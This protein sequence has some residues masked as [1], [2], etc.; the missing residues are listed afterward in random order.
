MFV[1]YNLSVHNRSLFV[2]LFS[3]AGGLDLGLEQA[4]WECVYASDLD[5]EAVASLRANQGRSVAEGV[6]FLGSAWVEQRDVCDLKAET[7][8]QLTGGRSTRIELLAGGPP[9]QAWSSAGLQLGFDD[10]RGRVAREF[11]R[12]AGELS[13]RWLLMENVRGLLT[14]RGPAGVPGEALDYLR[15]SLLALG[16]Q[17]AVQLLNAADYGV[18]QR[19][20]RLFVVGFRPGDEPHFPTQT[21]ARLASGSFGLERPWVTLGDALGSLGP[22][23]EAEV[24]RPPE[25]LRARLEALPAGRGLKSPGKPEATRPGGHWGYTQGSFV[26]DPLLPA[27]TVTASAQQDWVRDERWGLRRLTPREC[28]ALQT[29]PPGWEL[30]TRA[31]TAYRLIGNAVPPRLAYHLGR[32]LMAAGDRPPAGDVSDGELL[33]PL[34]RHLSAAVEYTRKEERRNGASRSAVSSRRSTSPAVWTHMGWCSRSSA[35]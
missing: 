9:C 20:V 16:Y 3:G 26:A 33:R 14:A 21:H 19:R 2:S 34:P 32:A 27:R 25:L 13:P 15:S 24:I 12:L 18:P 28:A 4:G 35:R 1:R 17:T 6:S 10:A 29:F 5:G 22:V 23:E 8:E 11:V 30:P 31:A 7:V